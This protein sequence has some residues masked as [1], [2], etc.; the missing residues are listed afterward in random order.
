[1]LDY[2]DQLSKWVHAISAFSG[3]LHSSLN[4]IIYAIYNQQFKKSYCTLL[5]KVTGGRFFKPSEKITDE[6]T[7]T[8]QTIKY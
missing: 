2:G 4:P 8:A 6:T 5:C 3:H 7:K 1:M